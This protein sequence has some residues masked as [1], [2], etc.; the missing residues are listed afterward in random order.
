MKNIALSLLL[1]TLLASCSL[2]NVS[3]E[4]EVVPLSSRQMNIRNGVHSYARAM[5]MFVASAA[6]SIINSQLDMNVKNDAI[7]WKL[8]FA[9][10]M[11]KAAF[12][13]DPELSFLDT[14]AF[15]KQH[16]IFFESSDG[17]SLFPENHD[18][19]MYTADSLL[20]AIE[21]MGSQFFKKGEFNERQSFIDQHAL[22]EPLE[23]L[24]FKRNFI[25]FRWK[26]FVNLPDTAV[27]STVGSL[28]QVMAEFSEKMGYYTETAPE[29]I[30]WKIDLI[31]NGISSDTTLQAEIDSL[32]ALAFRLVAVVESSPEL[33]D[34]T[35]MQLDK[36][37]YRMEGDFNNALAMFDRNWAMTL[38]VLPVERE[39]LIKSL[40]DEREIILE[41]LNELSVQVADQALGHIKGIIRSVL[42][43]AILFI[44][45]LFGIPFVSGFYLGKYLQ[46][47]K[48]TPAPDKAS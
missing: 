24:T 11:S 45:L 28:P 46:R 32:R 17:R 14:W 37:L 40:G 3:I 27:I 4:T 20:F 7:R 29:Q 9:G 21:T 8:G 19:V 16:K 39:N 12:I 34:S 15:I 38:E 33:I 42:L 5:N 43:F 48:N 30:Q 31:E 2:F 36:M 22:A 13:T 6:D 25:L 41:D 26:E 47:S 1:A 10:A 44:I 35:M 18:L 23:D